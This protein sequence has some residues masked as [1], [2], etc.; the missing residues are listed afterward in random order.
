MKFT[1]IRTLPIYDQ[2]YM[3]AIS[4]NFNLLNDLVYEAGVEIE[5]DFLASTINGP[6]TVEENLEYIQYSC[7][8]LFFNPSCPFRSLDV[9]TIA[10]E[11]FHAAEMTMERIG[12]EKDGEPMAYLVGFFASEI[13]SFLEEN[14]ISVS[15]ERPSFTPKTPV[16]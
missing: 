8:F 16:R 6:V 7:I 2:F 11:A 5:E 9:G 13:S 3:L 14:G 1:E 15:L 4:E 10:H 12:S